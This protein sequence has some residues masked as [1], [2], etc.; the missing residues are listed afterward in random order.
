MDFLHP[1][2]ILYVIFYFLDW[3]IIYAAKA[4]PTLRLA[5]GKTKLQ[6]Q[7][8]LIRFSCKKGFDIVGVKF[9]VCLPS[10][11][12]SQQKPTCVAPT[13][14]KPDKQPPNMIVEQLYKG[15]VLKYT[16]TAGV[17]RS[18]PEMLLCDG[19]QWS[20]QP[21]KCIESAALGCDFENDNLCGWS[22]DDTDDFDWIRTSGETPTTHTGPMFDHTTN[23]SKG[24][25]LFMESSAPQ[26]TGQKTRLISPQYAPGQMNNMCL[27]FYY[28]MFGTEG[29]G[30]VGDLDVYVRPQNVNTT[31]LNAARSIF[32]RS[33]NQGD[34]W[35]RGGAELKQQSLPFNIV[36]EATK[37]KSWSGDIAIDDVKLK[38]CSEQTTTAAQSGRIT[39]ANRNDDFITSEL[40]TSKITT[41]NL[42]TTKTTKRDIKQVTTPRSSSSVRTTR[43]V[44]VST[45]GST[46]KQL[47]TNTLRNIVTSATKVTSTLTPSLT[48]PTGR[49]RDNV[50]PSSAPF[51]DSG[52]ITGKM[53][54]STNKLSSVSPSLRTTAS[55]YRLDITNDNNNTTD[56]NDNINDNGG[57]SDKRGS[58]TEPSDYIDYEDPNSRKDVNESSTQN[59]SRGPFVDYGYK[60]SNDNGDAI[61]SPEE[62]DIDG[63][64]ADTGAVKKGARSTG[65][66]A[67]IP[68]IVGIVA[69]V[70]VGVIVIALLAWIWVRSQRQKQ[71]KNHDD[72]MNIITEYV[73]TN[74]NN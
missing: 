14:K 44:T 8:R 40:L 34:Q 68:L 18:G 4:C 69:S 47:I 50:S 29:V 71:E 17:T 15:G 1:C 41:K 19:S 37:L 56:G 33:G 32:H 10:G 36:F 66:P 22:Q 53:K 46:K 70:V 11:Q 57:I 31:Q 59:D 74:L 30:E 42:P 28:H 67:F 58:R 60:N 20:D 27:E 45:T 65:I 35:I 23:N 13:C 24:S 26:T 55:K 64:V 52:I 43:R 73:E 21:P 5:R 6:S 25:Y 16:C 38:K 63:L 62:D 48:K 3:N 9:A 51:G 7:G 54:A 39:N 2:W 72:Q 61:S 12:W 49:I